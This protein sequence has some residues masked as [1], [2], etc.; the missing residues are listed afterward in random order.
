MENIYKLCQQD[1]ENAVILGNAMNIRKYFEPRAEDI[2]DMRG[3][4]QKEDMD[5]RLEEDDLVKY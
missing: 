4:A 3:E 5:F 2:G 1:C